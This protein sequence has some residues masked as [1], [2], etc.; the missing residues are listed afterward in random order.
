MNSPLLPRSPAGLLSRSW[1]ALSTLIVCL[2]GFPQAMMAS[3]EWLVITPV[4][5]DTQKEFSLKPFYQKVL[6]IK[7]FPIVSS[8]SAKDEALL[9]AAYLIDKMLGDRVDILKAMASNHV[10]F[11]VMAYN[12]M[13]TQVPEHSDLTPASYWDRRAR[14][15]GAT[16]ARPSVSCGEENLLG[17]PGDPYRT[18]NIFIHEFAHAI[19][20]MGLNSVDPGFDERLLKVYDA[21]MAKGLWKGKYAAG[22]R[23]EYWAE[24]VQS[25]FDT[26]RENDHD[27]NHVNTRAELREYDPALAALV[28]EVFGD[29]PWRY[30]RPVERSQP[31]NAHLGQYDFKSSPKFEWPKGLPDKVSRNLGTEE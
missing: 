11:T 20:K 29:K 14:G 5:E 23:S 3:Q 7:G 6:L 16:K 25:W 10:R 27:H 2:V 31:E 18:E 1:L 19:H 21:A 17:F 28:Q 13:T 9:E 15:L 24:G 8:N 30:Q 4:P 12:E 22:N 26:N